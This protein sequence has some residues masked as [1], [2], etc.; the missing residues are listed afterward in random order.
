[1]CPD[2]DFSVLLRLSERCDQIVAA[3]RLLPLPQL[4]SAQ[5]APA[6]SVTNDF[7]WMRWVKGSGIT[8]TYGKKDLSCKFNK[9][10]KNKSFGV[11]RVPLFH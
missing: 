3:A 1:V 9:L 10:S 5:K 11:S 8:F 4:P 7:I 6:E 2:I